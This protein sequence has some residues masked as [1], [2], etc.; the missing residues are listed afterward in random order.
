MIESLEPVVGVKD[1]SC[2]LSAFGSTNRD[3]FWVERS[4]HMITYDCGNGLI[5]QCAADFIKQKSWKKGR[6]IANKGLALQ[7]WVGK[8]CRGGVPSPPGGC[9]PKTN[10]VMLS[11]GCHSSS[12]MSRI[13]PLPL[14]L[15]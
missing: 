6:R 14:S 9:L 5:F 12:A 3:P 15:Q 11:A 7:C 10:P 1:A 8:N 13:F 4:S 2:I